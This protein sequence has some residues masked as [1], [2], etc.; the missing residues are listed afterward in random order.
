MNIKWW[1]KMQEA[2][3]VG[4]EGKPKFKRYKWFKD[5]LPPPPAKI[6]EMG[7]SSGEAI[8]WI[9]SFGYDCTA[10]D[11]PIV[12]EKIKNK[13]SKIEYVGANLDGI[14]SSDLKRNWVGEFDAIIAGEILQH[15]VF[16]ENFI[17]RAWHYLKN[18][19]RFLLSTENTKLVRGAVRFYPTNIILGMFKVLNFKVLEY[20]T[21]GQ[22]EYIWICAEKII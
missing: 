14:D 20:T 5:R 10:V 15:L 13:N 21:E 7:C 22:R 4:R 16:D 6:M 9:A 11:F 1:N 8:N 12:I 18:G 17:Y 19:G 2:F 3:K